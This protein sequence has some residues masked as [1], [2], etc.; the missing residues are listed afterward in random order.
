[1]FTARCELKF[2]YI[3]LIASSSGAGWHYFSSWTFIQSAGCSILYD[4]ISVK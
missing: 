1:M 3:S 2:M 4:F